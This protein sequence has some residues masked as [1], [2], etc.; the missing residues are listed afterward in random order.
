VIRPKGTI[1]KNPEKNTRETVTGDSQDPQSTTPF[2]EE[3][4][5]HLAIIEFL[6]DAVS[7]MYQ[8]HQSELEGNPLFSVINHHLTNED[9]ATRKTV[10]H[11]ESERIVSFWVPDTTPTPAIVH[12]VERGLPPRRTEIALLPLERSLGTT[13]G[14][15]LKAFTATP[16]EGLIEAVL[17]SP[18]G[19]QE[20]RVNEFLEELIEWLEET[21]QAIV[22]ITEN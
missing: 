6:I 7:E 8:D 2:S 17:S 1:I 4:Q 15:H 12:V 22:V 16:L 18:I 11:P 9:G 19:D 13:S 5:G 21:L 20:D 10:W 14:E 3:V